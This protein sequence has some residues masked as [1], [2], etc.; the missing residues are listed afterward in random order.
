[1]WHSFRHR[2]SWRLGI[3]AAACVLAGVLFFFGDGVMVGR[4]ENQ[5]DI[6]L[7]IGVWTRN[8]R[9][10]QTFL[11]SQ[12]HLARIDFWI[13]S[14][15]A[16]DNPFIECRL[17]ELLIDRKP[18]ELSYHELHQQAT[19]VRAKRL[20]GWLFSPHMFNTFAFEPISDSQ[21]KRYL[22][23]M[24]SPELKRGGSSIILASPKK[25]L[26]DD[27]FVVDGMIKE[28]DLAFRALYALPRWQLLQ[29]AFARVALQKPAPFS[30]PFV[31]SLLF[32]GYF[33]LLLLLAWRLWHNL[34]DRDAS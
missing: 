14:Y 6:R 5:T 33:V 27:R 21:G 34:L 28:G 7:E 15:R 19:E 30:F 13:D 8:T 4:R 12:N 3:V 32:G 1:M 17:F 16:W 2:T 9:I 31:Y 23:V 22:F 25:R 10:E 20:N 24:Q 18:V 29:Q 26:D 11:A